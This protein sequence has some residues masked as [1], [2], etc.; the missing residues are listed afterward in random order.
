MKNEIR[1][2]LLCLATTA[3]PA[4]AQNALPQCGATNYDQTRGIFTIMNPAAGI[5]NQECLL[6]VYPK[7][8]APDQSRQ[9]PAPDLIE[10]NYVID[11]SGGGA[12]GAGGASKD[13]GGGGGGGGAVPSRTVKYLSPGVYKLTIGTG[14]QGGSANGGLIEGGAP[15]SLTNANTGEL[16][17]GSAG[18]GNWRQGAGVA[19]GFGGRGGVAV[20]GGSAG[21]SGGDSGPA[22]EEAAQPG[23]MSQTG[24]FSGRPG[25]AGGDYGRGRQANAGGGGGA[26]V[27]DGG[28][29]QAENSDSVAGVGDLGGGGGGGRGGRDTAGAGGRGG[30]GFIRLAAS[31]PV[32]QAVAPV[33]PV[34]G[35]VGQSAVTEPVP[36]ATRPARQARN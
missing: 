14:G 18:D 2:A 33:A 23:G 36:T 5:I 19:D 4:F 27:G 13:S 17:Y 11:L 7:G 30:H 15:T 24:G 28:D 35:A 21:G 32:P 6:T 9:L 29:G 34:T 22:A 26:G 31:D 1:L 10:G 20:A 12:G 8:T 3:A 25:R 16:V